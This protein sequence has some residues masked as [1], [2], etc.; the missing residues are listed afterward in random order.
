ML[1]LYKCATKNTN[2][3]HSRVHND[4]Y[5]GNRAAPPEEMIP[6]FDLAKES[7]SAFSIPNIGVVGYEADDCLGTVAHKVKN[8]ADVIILTG[9]R[10]IL[11][12]LDD[13]IKVALMKKGYGKYEVV[14]KDL[15]IETMGY[16]PRQFIDFK[17]LTGDA[18][19]HFP[20]V[21]GIG[22]KTAEKLIKEFGSVENILASLDQLKPSIRK[23]IEEDREN[24]LLSK[25]LAEIE[26]NV[27]L[28]F[29]LADAKISFIK[30][31]MNE[32]LA[33]L[34]I[35]GMDRLLG[36]IEDW[37]NAVV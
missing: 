20:G 36:M 8:E 12:V 18:S 10:D 24:L 30:K 37:K 32:H 15:F 31:E 6:Q 3:P 16:T 21:R 35:R 26:L 5:K 4:D 29:S 25:K 28:S 33:R 27:P 19:D 14:T 2:I 7:V 23:K 22:P 13:G 11:Q 9:D 1:D 34:E 17:G